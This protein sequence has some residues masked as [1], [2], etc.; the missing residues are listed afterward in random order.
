MIEEHCAEIQWLKSTVNAQ[1]SSLHERLT[2]IND[3]RNFDIV[4]PSTR[5]V[6]KAAKAMHDNGFD[7]GRHEEQ[8]ASVTTLEVH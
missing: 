8:Q 2:S 7:N 5:S 6:D 3:R 4:G 1:S